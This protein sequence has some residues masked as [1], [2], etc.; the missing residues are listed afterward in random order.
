MPYIE[1]N[2]LDQ[3]KHMDLWTSIAEHISQIA[4]EPFAVIRQREVG[5]GCINA[6]WVVEGAD[7]AY[8]VKT[9]GAAHAVMFEAEAAGL[10]QLRSADAIRVPTPLCYGVAG[11]KAYLVLEYIELGGHGSQQ[12]LGQALARLHR[13]SAP[14]FGWYRNNTIG[15]TPQINEQKDDWPRFWGEMRLAPQLDR[16]SRRGAPAGLVSAVERLIS[17]APAFFRG[18]SPAP[19]LVHGDLW[20]GNYG[21]DPAGRP[22]LFDPAVYYGDRETD[23]AMTELFGGFSSAFYDAYQAAWP[24]DAGYRARRDLYNLYHILNHFNLF[25]G[26]YGAQAQRM[27]ER[28]LSE[29]R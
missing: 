2:S 29:I 11:G 28:L 16:A 4:G 3:K 20:G 22:V 21:F 26:G 18:Y 5:G 8:F 7:A 17:D 14:R 23:L 27:A 6:A 19:S 24:L 12:A 25:G 9:N 15:S 10:V 13:V 1:L